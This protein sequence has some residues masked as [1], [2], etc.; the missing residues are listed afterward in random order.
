LPFINK[1]K[2]DDDNYNKNIL[3]Q[4]LQLI[5]NVIETIGKNKNKIQNTTT[6]KENIITLDIAISRLN[7]CQANIM[8]L[9][10][11]LRQRDKKIKKLLEDKDDVTKYKHEI[12]SYK[13]K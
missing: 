11:E 9:E 1:F 5:L 8:L 7:E 13:H 12:E 4:L 6:V 10:S 3:K 2:I